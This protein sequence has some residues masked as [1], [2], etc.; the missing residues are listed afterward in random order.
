VI[1]VASAALCPAP[2]LAQGGGESPP[3]GAPTEPPVPELRVERPGGKPLIW[4]GQEN[5]QLLGGTWYFRQDDENVGD[6][7]RWYQQ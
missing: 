5:R 7:Q 4:E 6:S 3:G 2:A 1:L